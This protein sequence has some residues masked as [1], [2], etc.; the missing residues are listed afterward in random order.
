MSHRIL[1]VDD[2][3]D[4]VHLMSARLI[5]NNFDVLT[6][7][8]AMAAVS[9]A[10]V[11]RPNLIILDIRLPGGGGF[12]VY[13]NLRASLRT[14]RI[15]VLFVTGFD[16]VGPDQEK[17]VRDSLQALN[18]PFLIKPFSAEELMKKVNQALK[19]PPGIPDA[20]EPALVKEI[21]DWISGS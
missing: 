15:P 21:I 18:Y 1:I 9:I 4:F 14:S 7:F 19:Q 3:V 10:Q 16:R 11:K 20:N 17:K 5:A 6:A 12:K 13:E 8:D 2:D